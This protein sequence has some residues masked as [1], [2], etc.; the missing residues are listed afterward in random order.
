MSCTSQVKPH[1]WIKIGEKKLKNAVI[2]WMR[3]DTSD[4]ATVVY[5]DNKGEPIAEEAQCKGDYW[6]FVIQ[7]PCGSYAKS[8]SQYAPFVATLKAGQYGRRY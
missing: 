3:S 5:F 4:I 7:G 1:D 6:D 8:L 2:C